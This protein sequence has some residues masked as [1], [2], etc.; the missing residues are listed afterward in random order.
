MSILKPPRPAPHYHKNYLAPKLFLDLLSN[1]WGLICSYSKRL[2]DG[3]ER[4]WIEEWGKISCGDV[5]MWLSYLR[6]W[7]EHV[8]GR[9]AGDGEWRERHNTRSGN[10]SHTLWFFSGGGMTGLGFVAS[11]RLKW[12]LFL[13]IFDPWFGHLRP[14]AAEEG[15]ETRNRRHDENQPWISHS[16]FYLWYSNATSSIWKRID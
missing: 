8:W 15:G 10:K 13:A 16:N 4:H 12:G 2:F 3:D 14:L 5:H 11:E 6:L 1:V 9:I 7:G